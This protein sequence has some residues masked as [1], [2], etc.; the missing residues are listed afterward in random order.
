MSHMRTVVPRAPINAAAGMPA[1][2]SHPA[3]PLPD[4]STMTVT[5]AAEA[6]DVTPKMSGLARA[7]RVTDCV[8]APDSARAVPT[9]T[10][11]IARGILHSNTTSCSIREPPPVKTTDKTSM[12]AIGKSPIP[13][14]TAKR[15]IPAM[16]S[17]THTNN[18]RGDS[19]PE[20]GPHRNALRWCGKR[21][22][23]CCGVVIL[24]PPCYG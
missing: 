15:N 14:A 12:G 23:L 24:P 8:S 20:T 7:L 1:P 19:T 13:I 17:A 10:A 22:L 2:A 3:K 21:T 9:I 16:T 11:D 4:P 18:G 6:P 5:A